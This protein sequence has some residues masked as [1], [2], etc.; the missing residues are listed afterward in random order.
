MKAKTA[1]QVQEIMIRHIQT[2]TPEMSMVEVMEFLD[3]H[4]L[5][6]APV[7][8]QGADGRKM[9]VGFISEG[10]CLAFLANEVFFGG[11]CPVQT[12]RTMMKRHPICVEPG[13]D[14]F[15]LASIFVSHQHRHLPVVQ[16]GQLL[17][18]VDRR[19]VLKAL[20]AYYREA[21]HD[22]DLAK[23]PPDLHEALNLRCF[24]SKGR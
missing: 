18:M 2:V 5:T 3:R 21:I 24:V 4:H 16:D 9:L 6:N 13:T 22:R 8:E 14:L 23:F 1:P 15:S 17:G 12:V 20:E 11:P 7:I 19:D 10:D